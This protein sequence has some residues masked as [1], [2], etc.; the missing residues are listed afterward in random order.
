VCLELT[1]CAIDLCLVCSRLKGSDR[2]SIKNA[3]AVKLNG[4]M[5]VSQYKLLFYIVR[6]PVDETVNID[7]L[8][9]ISVSTEL[10]ARFME[11][12]WLRSLL[13]TQEGKI[14]SSGNLVVWRGK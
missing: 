4:P 6:L 7:P 14:P 5:E 1:C 10:D 11:I 8:L 3:S 13:P 2:Q 12:A 9:D